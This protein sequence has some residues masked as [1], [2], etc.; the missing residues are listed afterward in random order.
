[1]RFEFCRRGRTAQAGSGRP[2]LTRNPQ[3]ND[4][5]LTFAKLALLVALAAPAAGAQCAMCYESAAAASKQGQR[6][7]SKAVIVLLVPPVSFMA[8]LLGMVNRYKPPAGE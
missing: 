6:T 1:M 2:R 7:L 8:V 4:M 5:R 3:R